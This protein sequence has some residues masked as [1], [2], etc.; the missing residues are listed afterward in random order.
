MLKLFFAV[1]NSLRYLIRIRPD[2]VFATGGYVSAPVVIAAGL[3]RIP[4]FIH[5]Q[6]AIFGITN[7][8]AGRFART[9]FTTFRNTTF[10]RGFWGKIPANKIIFSGLPVRSEFF[11]PDRNEAVARFKLDQ[12]K[13]TIL[14]TG[15]SRGARFINHEIKKIYP[16][17]IKNQWQL[18]HVIGQRDFDQ[19]EKEL[20]DDQE[21]DQLI[22]RYAYLN[23]MHD[24][25]A[26]ADLCISRAGASFLAEMTVSGRPGILIP[27]PYATHN[28]QVSN[29]QALEKEGAVITIEEKQIEDNPLLLQETIEKIINDQPLSELM[30]K[31][32]KTAGTVNTLQVI[33]QN[34]LKETGVFVE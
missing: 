7:R 27:F 9:V 21:R 29:A 26:V 16:F 24:A 4:F 34:I 17:F 33:E 23:H 2:F 6:N 8:I 28:H 14:V 13:K 5:E 15:G 32:A 1:I 31:A 22:Q 10:A 3:L 25:L 12:S 19:F 20:P 11:D 18:I 30:R